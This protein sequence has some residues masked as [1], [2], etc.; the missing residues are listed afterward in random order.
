MTD[1]LRRVTFPQWLL[2]AGL[3]GLVLFFRAFSNPGTAW[4]SVSGLAFSPDGKKLAVSIHS[5]RFQRVRSKWYIA[6][7]CR[8]FALAPL[9]SPAKPVV[10]AENRS[11]GIV[12]MLPEV[13]IG[14][15]VAFSA[16]GAELASAGSGGEVDVWDVAGGGL[17]RKLETKRDEVRSVAALPARNGFVASFRYWLTFW[18]IGEDAPPKTLETRCNIQAV[19]VS[20]DNSQIA[21]GSLG[22]FAIEIW[23]TRSGKRLASIETA[24]EPDFGIRSMTYTRDGKTLIVADGQSVWSID[25]ASK[26]IRLLLPE[27]LVLALA[28]SP[29]GRALA[30]GRY[31]GIKLWNL[32]TPEGPVFHQPAPAV[33]S[34]QFHPDSHSLAT[35]SLDGTVRLWDAQSG[36]LQ[37]TWTF[38]GPIRIESLVRLKMGLA[39]CWLLGGLFVFRR[40]LFKQAAA[41]I[42]RGKRA[43]HVEF[44]NR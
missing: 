27:R 19:A 6:D 3:V 33:E 24:E 15:A 20:P 7:L 34:V 14:P 37:R 18:K 17:L 40:P 35:G 22:A 4:Q 2:A 31:D 29:D 42:A 10:L 16:D 38:P 13:A 9:D 21:V 23:D 26:A 28:V 30:T 39:G 43:R 25:V 32:A 41:R 36:D 12:N 8:T 44:G 11:S 1:W 5:G